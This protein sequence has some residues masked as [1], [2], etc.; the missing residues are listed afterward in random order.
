LKNL[1]EAT[2]IKHILNAKSRKIDTRRGICVSLPYMVVGGDCLRRSLPRLQ[3]LVLEVACRGLLTL[4]ATTRIMAFPP[5]EPNH[6]I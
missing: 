1:N 2:S 3:E 5:A 6:Y 4:H